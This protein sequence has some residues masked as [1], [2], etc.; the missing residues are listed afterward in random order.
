MPRHFK[1]AHSYVSFFFFVLIPAIA[2]ASSSVTAD[3]SFQ[4]FIYSPAMPV[5]H[6]DNWDGNLR[7]ATFSHGHSTLKAGLRWQRL[8]ISLIKRRDFWASF[9]SDTAELYHQLQT[10][11]EAETGRQYKM[12]LET[13]DLKSTGFML[14]YR[15]L[16]SRNI[17][18]EA[19]G[20]YLLAN[21]YEFSHFEGSA[22]R[23][24]N[25]SLNREIDNIDVPFTTLH[26]GSDCL[27]GS[28]YC[29]PD[30][31]RGL[32][33]SF[34][35][36]LNTQGGIGNLELELIDIAS[37]IRWLQL[38][39]TEGKLIPYVP[40]KPTPTTY[41]HHELRLPRKAI[42]NISIPM[43]PKVH[44]LG[45]YHY[46]EGLD[47]IPDYQEQ[48]IGIG[49]SANQFTLAFMQGL[50]LEKKELSLGYRCL[51]GNLGFDHW[52]LNSNRNLTLGMSV[53]LNSKGCEP[54]N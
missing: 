20:T 32:G 27:I 10:D 37:K 19:S 44:L 21:H 6:V 12:Q 42:L 13:H 45:R 9:N 26:Q 51:T 5:I 14:S 48:S 31:S 29:P 35:L 36:L 30:A 41:R 50:E 53:T 17:T 34:D 4:E 24:F 22:Q 40:I 8:S 2:H 16:E 47:Q 49:Y 3:Y 11:G 46:I 33:Y 54:T 38:A 23:Y 15:I 39:K 28:R 18:V 25:Q 43:L 7:S 52:Q 1:R